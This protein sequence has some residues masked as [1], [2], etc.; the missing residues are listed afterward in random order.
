VNV[1]L[2][3]RNAQHALQ[4]RV[5]RVLDIVP[6]LTG[7][8]RVVIIDDGSTDETHDV[9]LDLARRYPQ[10]EAVRHP[11]P[12]GLDASV[13]RT[14]RAGRGELVLVDTPEQPLSPAE[15]RRVWHAA[16]PRTDAAGERAGRRA[17]RP[18]TLV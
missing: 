8:F 13:E 16:P 2:P 1:L 12:V 4:Q 7:R 9:A 15:L 14:R 10:V 18:S 11:S 17:S 6:E 3:V 5:E